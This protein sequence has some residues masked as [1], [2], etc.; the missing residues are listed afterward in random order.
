MLG[1]AVVVALAVGLAGYLAIRPDTPDPVWAA[2]AMSGWGLGAL[3][4]VVALASVLYGRRG[5]SPTTA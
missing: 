3:G 1:V 5:P 4:A 2:A